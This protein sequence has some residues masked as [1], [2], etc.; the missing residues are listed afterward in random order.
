MK[1]LVC[2]MCGGANLVKQEGV[3]VCQNCKTKYSVEE[4]KRMMI[5][6]TVD[7]SGSTVKVDNTDRLENLYKLA[8]R[9]REEGNFEKTIEYYE[10]ILV[11][12]PNC[13]EA[14]FHSALSSSM[15]NFRNDKVS[16]AIDLLQNCVRSTFDLLEKNNQDTV[17]Q[18]L[19]VKETAE[20]VTDVCEIYTN[21]LYKNWDEFWKSY[22]KTEASDHNNKVYKEY[23][24]RYDARSIAISE[25][26][27]SLGTRV[28]NMF[29]N[30]GELGSKAESMFEKAIFEVE[31]TIDIKKRE[32]KEIIDRYKIQ[33]RI[34]S[35]EDK[36]TIFKQHLA[37]KQ[38]DEINSL[39]RQNRNMIIGVVI[40]VILGITVARSE[41]G[42]FMG[43]LL[44]LASVGF[45]LIPTVSKSVLSWIKGWLGEPTCY[46][47]WLFVMPYAIFFYTPFAGISR[48]FK[49][50]NRLKE[51]QNN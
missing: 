15:L 31:R 16:T 3:F 34:A 11:D 29:G 36:A 18:E 22:M 46:I 2:E 23:K 17:E 6:G 9:A 28:L 33:K 5:E 30:G 39:K 26:Y 45:S 27:V 43:V 13:W 40:G 42:A 8:R 38:D 19:Y 41:M 4:A 14:V 25:V 44:V 32:K 50:R 37:D 47:V 21:V 24:D 12:E 20:N 10:Q 48:Y 35:G 51:L 49:R 7:V 1:A